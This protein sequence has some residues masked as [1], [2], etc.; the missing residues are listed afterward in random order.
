MN[1]SISIGTKIKNKED[2]RMYN[3]FNQNCYKLNSIKEQ[4]HNTLFAEANTLNFKL[5][6][7]IASV[8]KRVERPLTLNNL[9]LEFLKFQPQ[10]LKND[11]WIND[12]SWEW[13]DEMINEL[14]KLCTIIA[15]KFDFKF[16]ELNHDLDNSPLFVIRYADDCIDTNYLSDYMR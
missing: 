12:K 11:K 6:F 13:S 8:M 15:E 16:I 2:L 9:G 4:F 5:N 7:Q 14:I 1:L 3:Y 10:I